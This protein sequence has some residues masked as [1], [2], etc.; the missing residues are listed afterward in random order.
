MTLTRSGFSQ[1]RQAA[2]KTCAICA[3]VFFP[4][5]NRL[6]ASLCSPV[7][8]SKYARKLE[9]ERKAKKRAERENDKQRKENLKS[10]TEL[11]G[12]CREIVQ[13]IARIRDAHDG[14]IS[15]HMGPNY[16]GQWHGS[17]YF[18]AGNHG[19]VQFSLWNIHKSCAQCNL[20][21]SGN[22]AAYR[23]RL[24]AKIGQEK[25]DWL[26]REKGRIVKHNAVYRAYLLRFKQV[27][28]KRLKRLEKQQ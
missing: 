18:P 24:I 14:C 7:C 15:C 10:Y 13:A 11:E 9:A 28:G 16:D 6:T 27:M 21:K 26:E 19:A 1:E 17:H 22:Q 23:P 8:G 5:A 25:F 12:E 20:F 2:E 4:A 3:R